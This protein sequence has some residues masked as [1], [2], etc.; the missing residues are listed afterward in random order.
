MGFQHHR[1]ESR[2]DRSQAGS[3]VLPEYLDGMQAFRLP[4]DAPPSPSRS[5][6]PEQP[7]V[8]RKKGAEVTMEVTRL[9]QHLL[10]RSAC[11]LPPRSPHSPESSWDG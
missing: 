9:F 8:D 7:D 4:C 1:C 6:F 5:F 10:S 2:I 3:R 11:H